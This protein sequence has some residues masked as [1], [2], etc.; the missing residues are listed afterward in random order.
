MELEQYY[1]DFYQPQYN[2]RKI[3]DSNRGIKRSEEFKR[4]LS[5]LKSGI[6]HT[7][8]R[9]RKLSESNKAN[10]NHMLRLKLS[11]KPI[12]KICKQTLLPIKLYISMA[13][14][15]RQNNMSKNA[16]ASA[17]RGVTKSSCGFL[18]KYKED[19]DVY[20]GR[21]S[22]WGNPFAIG[23][24]GTREE[25]IELYRAHLWKMLKK[26]SITKQDLLDLDGKRLG[27]FCKPQ[28]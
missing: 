13:E 25:V 20:I 18:W 14:A 22:V 8:E 1:L 4:N 28:T 9:K 27:C 23:E 5:K 24:H 11:G 3:V 21:G 7:E 16:I 19:Y 26:G 6:P 15:A 2:S 10:E 12:Y 17:A